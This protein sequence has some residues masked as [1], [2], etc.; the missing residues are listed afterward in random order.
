MIGQGRPCSP[1]EAAVE[2]FKP[3]GGAEMGHVPVGVTFVHGKVGD[4]RP[5]VAAETM[6][7]L[8]LCQAILADDV[9]IA[10]EHGGESFGLPNV[11]EVAENGFALPALFL[12][13][14]VFA[15]DTNGVVE[16]AQFVEEAA[17]LCSA[18]VD[19]VK[20]GTEARPAIMDDEF[21]AVV[22]VSDDARAFVLMFRTGIMQSY[23]QYPT[24]A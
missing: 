5:E 15:A 14:E 3:A 22:P 13:G 1:T 16:V 10:L 18:E 2:A 19:D 21:Q 12:A 11:V 8:W 20:G 23:S 17:L 24:N 7:G 4:G 6:H 9:A